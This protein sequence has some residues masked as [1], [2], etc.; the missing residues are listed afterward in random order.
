MT[1][2]FTESDLQ[3]TI[4][5]A[6][7]AR[8]FDGQGHGLLHCM[9]AVDFVVELSDRLYFIEF[10]DPQ[11][12]HATAQARQQF[13]IDIESGGLDEDLKYK[14]RDSFLYEL[15]C[16]R[17][18]KPVYFLVLIGLDSFDS[19]QQQRRTDS[20]RG[21]LPV[22]VPASWTH[23]IVQGCIVQGCGVFNLASWNQQFPDLQVRRL[24]VPSG[25]PG[26]PVA[27]VGGGSVNRRLDS[28]RDG[29]DN[30]SP[31]RGSSGGRARH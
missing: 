2:V 20:L 1:T 23:P 27:Q 5:N 30:G 8:R 26:G 16:G 13:I 29:F 24:S 4:D 18:N 7:N 21:K 31:R 17:V 19:T 9:K 3:L 15:A 11:H 6:V 12:P 22:E 28:G 14:Y 10:K 25:G